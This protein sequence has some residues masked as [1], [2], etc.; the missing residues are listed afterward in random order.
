MTKDVQKSI[1]R[2][3]HELSLVLDSS[4]NMIS[5]FS[6]VTSSLSESVNKMEERINNVQ[7]QMLKYYRNVTASS[8]QPTI[9]QK[10]TRQIKSLRRSS[11]W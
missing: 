6:A 3:I 11:K 2:T 7:L 1:G 10:I 8:M 9:K 5:T 4:E